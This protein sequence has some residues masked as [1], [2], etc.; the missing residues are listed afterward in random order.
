MKQTL[1]YGRARYS[2]DD[3]D[4]KVPCRPSPMI[5]FSPIK[6]NN[7][8]KYPSFTDKTALSILKWKAPSQ[9]TFKEAYIEW[10]CQGFW[11]EKDLGEG[12]SFLRWLQKNNTSMTWKP[13][14]FK[15]HDYFLQK[16]APRHDPDDELAKDHSFAIKPV[17]VNNRRIKLYLEDA[18][19]L[20]LLGLPFGQDQDFIQL[21]QEYVKCR[22]Q[23][24]EWRAPAPP[25][26][27]WV[28]ARGKR[29]TFMAGQIGFSY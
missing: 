22:F 21:V 29:P 6:I 5:T 20:N 14:D 28:K 1:N 18:A 8:I 12:R 24:E 11:H 10:Y 25:F 2:Y 23:W 9:T 17:E 19:I 16:G 3:F 27:D 13:H 15:L 4:P 26:L 7:K